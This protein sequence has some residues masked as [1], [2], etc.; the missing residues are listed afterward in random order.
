M[1]VFYLFTYEVEVHIYTTRLER[2]IASYIVRNK[3]VIR[4]R[5]YPYSN[6]QIHLQWDR[7]IL[8]EMN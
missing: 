4:L 5:I 7:R 2:G 6:G 8:G 3:F 1:N